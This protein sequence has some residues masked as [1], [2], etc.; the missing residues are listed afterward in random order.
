MLKALRFTVLLIFMILG[1]LISCQT[2][3]VVISETPLGIS[4]SRRAIVSVIG[5][6]RTISQNGRE[7][8]SKYYDKKDMFIEEP[9]KVKTRYYTKVVILGDRRPYDIAVEVFYEGKD[10]GIFEIIDS[11]EGRAVEVAK[12]IKQALIESREKRNVI[13]DFRSF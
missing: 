2:P 12:K 7:L 10:G 5:A 13:D 11:D 6:P 3:G 4:E 9:E 1:G 8:Y